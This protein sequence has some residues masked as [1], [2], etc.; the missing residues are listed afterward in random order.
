MPR[1][2][3]PRW[4]SAPSVAIAANMPPMMSLT[5]VPARNGSPG[6]PVMYARP[7]IICTTSSSAVR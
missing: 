6:R 2:V 1:P 7:P 4:I 3:T 5:L